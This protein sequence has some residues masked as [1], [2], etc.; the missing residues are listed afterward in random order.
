MG[1]N[2]GP[3]FGLWAATAAG[4]A[5]VELPVVTSVGEND[6]NVSNAI[7]WPN[8]TDGQISLQA[9]LG[10]EGAINLSIIDVMGRTVKDFGTRTWGAG[11]NRI[12]LDLGAESNGLYFISMQGEDG[13][14][15]IPVQVN[16]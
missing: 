6:S 5:L 15:R 1:N 2:N 13:I 8:P 12:D 4:G 7:A 3:A 9:D 14:T 16:H 10:M 11:Q